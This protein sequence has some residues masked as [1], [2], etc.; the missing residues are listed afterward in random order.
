MK[1]AESRE[2]AGLTDEAGGAGVEPCRSGQARR[3]SIA[4]LAR[5]QG[6]AG[7]ASHGADGHRHGTNEIQ[8]RHRRLRDPLRD[9]R[10]GWQVGSSACPCR[11][12]RAPGPQGRSAGPGPVVGPGQGRFDEAL[13]LLED[14]PASAWK[15][16]AVA[17]AN[18]ARGPAP[19]VAREI[20]A[21][22]V[23]KLLAR[24][25]KPGREE[26]AVYAERLALMDDE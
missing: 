18:A 13:A 14:L 5:S 21:A 11:D 1:P 12:G 25:T 10:G 8:D 26:A 19:A 3:P 7:L 24:N 6:Q 17:L 22:L 2:S 9:S 20:Y 15:S 16:A 23:D 4:Q